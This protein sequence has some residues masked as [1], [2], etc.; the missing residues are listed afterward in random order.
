MKRKMAMIT[1]VIATCVAAEYYKPS[2]L[3]TRQRVRD[4]NLSLPC[5]VSHRDE[6][7]ALLL[8]TTLC[9]LGGIHPLPLL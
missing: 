7:Q 6:S 8:F 4:I 5:Y 3:H 9:V 2:S 1:M